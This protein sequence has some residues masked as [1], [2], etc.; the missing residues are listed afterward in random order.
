MERNAKARYYKARAG[1]VAFF[2]EEIH[3]HTSLISFEACAT[4]ETETFNRC[5]L[6]THAQLRR[7][8]EERDTVTLLKGYPN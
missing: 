6:T 8:R 1:K 7:A 2:P 5:K 3:T 4:S